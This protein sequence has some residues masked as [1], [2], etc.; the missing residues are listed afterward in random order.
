MA[1]K[2]DTALDLSNGTQSNNSN[3]SVPDSASHNIDSPAWIL[4][5]QLVFCISTF[6]DVFAVDRL[7]EMREDV[8]SR[9]CFYRF[10]PHFLL[11]E[12]RI[13]TCMWFVGTWTWIVNVWWDESQR[14][15]DGAIRSVRRYLLIRN[16]HRFATIRDV[17][18]AVWQ[19]NAQ[20]K[21]RCVEP[22]GR[23]FSAQTRTHT[24]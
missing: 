3:Y 10:D 9:Q 7:K 2:Q 24:A 8:N 22:A 18:V 4:W 13:Y 11:G 1:S 14:V 15:R 12:R 19:N 6:L 23:R 16:Y 17:V 5:S 20:I 21:T